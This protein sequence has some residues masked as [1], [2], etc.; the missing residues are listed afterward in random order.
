M[1]FERFFHRLMSTATAGLFL[2]LPVAIILFLGFKIWQIFFNPVHELALDA[3]I[4]HTWIAHL[5]LLTLVFLLCFLSGLMLRAKSVSKFRDFLE[6]SF[7][8][9]IPGYEY[10]R[11]R[12]MENFGEDSDNF[13][14]SALVRVDDGWSPCMLIEQHEDGRCIVYIPNVPRTS[15]GSIYIVDPDRVIHLHMRYRELNRCIRNYGEGL[16][17]IQDVVTKTATRL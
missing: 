4:S 5:I 15:S 9:L 16:F 6:K 2:M 14:R 17:N 11:L 7:L 1:T 13:D 3:G 10:V 12:L 8:K